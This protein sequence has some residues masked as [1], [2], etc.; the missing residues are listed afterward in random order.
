MKSEK[1]LADKIVYIAGPLN[2]DVAANVKKALEVSDM[3]ARLHVGY[4]CPHF[5]GEVHFSLGIPEKY[6]IEYG[7]EMLRRS[8]AVILLSNWE[9]SSGTLGEIEEA[10]KM[11]IPVFELEDIVDLLK[12]LRSL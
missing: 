10:K 3:L 12:Y 8:D 7:L 6:W 2:G 11:D 5:Y 1:M 4:F 9:K